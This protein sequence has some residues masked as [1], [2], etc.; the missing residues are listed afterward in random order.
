MYVL[1]ESASTIGTEST[2]VRNLPATIRTVGLHHPRY[3]LW[4][5]RWTVR[6]VISLERTSVVIDQ[7]S[8]PKKQQQNYQNGEVVI[9]LIPHVLPE[10]ALRYSS[11]L[12]A[13]Q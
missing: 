11:Y 7:R 3:W 5:R 1:G 10:H 13:Q 8:W 9:P 2:D 4:S 12:R 6:I